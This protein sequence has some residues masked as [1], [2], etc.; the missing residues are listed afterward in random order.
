MK[1]RG[2][3]LSIK[4]IHAKAIKNKLKLR[5]VAVDYRHPNVLRAAPAPLYTRFVDVLEFYHAVREGISEELE[6]GMA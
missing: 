6:A 4:T 2:A 3:Q 1:Q 5:G